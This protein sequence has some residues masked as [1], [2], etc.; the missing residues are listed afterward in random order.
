MSPKQPSL[1]EQ[2]EL[3]RGRKGVKEIKKRNGV[4]CDLY[5][6]GRE[7]K[8]FKTATQAHEK[9]NGEGRIE[10]RGSP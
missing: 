1:S 2:R 5:A 3:S 10:I 4:P 6:R 9:N 7:R 8:R